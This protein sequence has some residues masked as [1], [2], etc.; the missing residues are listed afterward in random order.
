MFGFSVHCQFQFIARF[1]SLAL[2]GKLMG[3]MTLSNTNFTTE[4][5]YNW[6]SIIYTCK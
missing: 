4:F 2:T 3:P 6:V 1:Q 5:I